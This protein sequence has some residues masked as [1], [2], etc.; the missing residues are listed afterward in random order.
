MDRH[1]LIKLLAMPCTFLNVWYDLCM[2]IS[3]RYTLLNKNSYKYSIKAFITPITSPKQAKPIHA[4]E[5]CHNPHY[6]LNQLNINYKNG[7]YSN[8]ME[9]IQLVQVMV[10]IVW[11]EWNTVDVQRFAGAKPFAISTPLKFLQK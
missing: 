9:C 1:V 5:G 10:K 4:Q 11:T 7:P 6:R 3:Y 2:N 8:V